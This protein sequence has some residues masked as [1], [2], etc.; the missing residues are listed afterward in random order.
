MGDSAIVEGVENA[1]AVPLGKLYEGKFQNTAA[2]GALWS[3]LGL[4]TGDLADLMRDEF[5][6]KG[7]ET[8]SK[9]VEAVEK[10]CA[11]AERHG[12]DSLRLEKPR[13]K[14][15]RMVLN[16]NEAIALG[17]ASAGLR[18]CSFYPMTPA[19]SIPLTLISIS[20]EMG[21][22]VEQAED[23]I[24]A[25]NMAIGA[26]Y[27]G[28]PAMV[29]TSGGGFALMQE[30]V[31]LAGMTETPL[32][33]VVAQ[34]PGPAT[35]LPTRTEQADLEFVLYS[36]HGEFPRAIFAPGD[37]EECFHLTRAAFGLAEEFQTPVFILTDQFL[38]DSSR[39]APPF[40]VDGL[41]WIEP[42]DDPESVEEPYMRY[43]M[44]GDGVSPRLLPGVSRHLVVADSDEHD[45]EGHI[46]E[47]LGIRKRMV[48]KRMTKGL[49]IAGQIVPPSYDGD[50]EPDTLLVCWGST[51]GSALEAA[52]A[53]RERGGKAGV[54]HF[55]QVWPL[56]P[57]Q[58]LERFDGPERIVCVESNAT[59][60]FARLIHREAGREISDRIYRYDGL[61]ITP[62]YIL[63]GLEG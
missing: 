30:G 23:E 5:G 15:R 24:A 59:G 61:P 44:T 46:T 52:A 4:D 31:S 42:G 34:R 41:E 14:R 21:I 51:K 47:D 25:V 19:T 12:P 37:I 9:N 6:K 39:A 62:G 50:D 22:V 36:G 38:A 53:L 11:W 2:L 63:E 48:D 1:F 56:D 33:V 27:A 17:A 35:G 58:F 3:I 16:G 57:G 18:F 55:S 29:A 32:V 60:Q 49:G 40:E 28:A 26:S 54:L 45:E 7:E 10:G 20:K 13:E 8:V 43:R